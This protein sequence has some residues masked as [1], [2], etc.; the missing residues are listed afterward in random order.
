MMYQNLSY[1]RSSLAAS[2]E[3]PPVALRF[4]QGPGNLPSHRREIINHRS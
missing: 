4:R 1:T 2:V 3:D